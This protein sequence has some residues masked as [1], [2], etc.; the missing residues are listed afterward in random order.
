MVQPRCLAD[1]RVLSS[2]ECPNNTWALST[3]TFIGISNPA[4]A[5]S[6]GLY[7]WMYAANIRP[8]FVGMM[9]SNVIF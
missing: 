7:R 1:A 9:M 3:L 8:S 2:S 4:F 5:I 6:V